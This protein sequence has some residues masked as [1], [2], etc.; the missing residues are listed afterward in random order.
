MSISEPFPTIEVENASEKGSSYAMPKNIR[1]SVRLSLQ[2]AKLILLARAVEESEDP[3]IKWTSAD[4]E[5]ASLRAAHTV[6]E[7]ADPVKLLTERAKIVLRS[8]SDRGASTALSTKARLPRLF[9][10]LFILL[11]FVLGGLTDRIASPEH[12]VNLLSPPYW[13]VI[14]WNLLVY[15]GLFCCAI[16]LVGNHNNRFALPLRSTLNALAEKASYG[17]LRRK[18]FKA[19]FYAAWAEFVAPLVRMHVA[20]T[21]HLAALAFALGIIVSLLVRGLG[22]AYWAG[23]ES[24][25]LAESPETVKSFI[26]YTFGLIPSV[27]PLTPMPDLAAVT[28]MRAD[29]L[30]YLEQPVSAAPWLL[31]MMILMTVVVILPR[32]IFA[33]FDSW[34]MKRFAAHTTLNLESPYFENILEQCSQDAVIG[35]LLVVTSTTN[36]P[37][38]DD[39]VSKFRKHWGGAEDSS[40][41]N[42]DFN[43]GESALP[44]LPEGPRRPI[45][46]LWLDGMETPE[47]DVHGAVLQRLHDAFE[48]DGK[49]VLAAML[50]MKEFADRFESMPHRIKE[51]QECW[52]ALAARHNIRL[53]VYSD[54]AEAQ[55]ATVKSLRAW[56]APRIPTEPEYEISNIENCQI[57]E[58]P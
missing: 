4:A 44:A 28:E 48:T 30:P 5:E 42:M 58:I 22:T 13:G 21:L 2:Q 25:W 10:P 50:D 3:H 15:L 16:G 31:R 7:A 1:T 47:E 55:L 8:A 45:V 26:D 32:L 29:R 34:R 37:A 35:N 12:I 39:D 24:T 57:L 27:G 9:A 38:R 41:A 54:T 23:W 53:F 6:G 18:G 19:R 43:D 14:V 20:R 40:A 36:R 11:A 52:E 56:A 49:A 46:L 17:T 33:I 51:R